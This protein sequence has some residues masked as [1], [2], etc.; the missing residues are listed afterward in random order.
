MGRPVSARERGFAG[1]QCAVPC[2]VFLGLLL[3]LLEI[4]CAD[5]KLK[6]PVRV[7]PRTMTQPSPEHPQR[8]RHKCVDLCC[9]DR[10]APG[11]TRP[12]TLG[13]MGRRSEFLE[14]N[15]AETREFPH[16]VAVEK[17][18][19]LPPRAA[20]FASPGRRRRRRPQLVSKGVSGNPTRENE[21][22]GERVIG[23]ETHLDL[24]A[25]TRAG[26]AVRR[27]EFSLC[28]AGLFVVRISVSV[29][30]LCSVTVYP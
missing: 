14:I 16:G 5:G 21:A 30:I 2:L 13:P 9:W 22:R 24:N 7:C 12:W 20:V 26:L 3:S 4:P 27:K 6:P 8:R 15:T 10:I 29:Q 19:S 11:A 25:S 18:W 28:R 1:L 17:E 23:G